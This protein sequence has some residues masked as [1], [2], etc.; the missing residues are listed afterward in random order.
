MLKSA[1]LHP[2]ILEALGRSGHGSQVLIADGNYPFASRCGP[3]ATKVYLNLAPG[4]V[5][6]TDVLRV[7]VDSIPIESAKLMQTPGNAKAPI[8]DEYVGLLPA[9]I[10]VK[11]LERF[12]FYD[13]ACSPATTLLIATGEIRRFANVLLTIGVVKLDP[14]ETY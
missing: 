8:H 1:L 14:G 2:Q 12:A 5:K 11:A 10:E 3:Q 7:L 13:A 4:I 9:G 6:A